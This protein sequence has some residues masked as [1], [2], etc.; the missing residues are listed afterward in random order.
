[1]AVAK[2][3]VELFYDVL[4]PYSWVAFEV[5]CRYQT[6]W[7]LDLQFRPFF[8]SGIMAGSGNK[9]PGTVPAKAAYMSKDIERLRDFYGIPL[10][11]PADPADV[12]FRKGSLSA[13]RLV[14]AA[15]KYYPD[16]VEPLSREFWMRIW[17]RDEDITEPQSLLEVCQNIGLTEHQTQ[18]LAFGAPI[19]VAHVNGKPHMYFGSDRFLLLAN[20]LGVEWEGPLVPRNSNL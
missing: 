10:V 5:L 2:R 17:S 1:M 15:T 7:N 12:M 11:P 13:M 6:K 4:S 9:P 18:S 19:I 3:T 14:T 16:K 8:L 20:L